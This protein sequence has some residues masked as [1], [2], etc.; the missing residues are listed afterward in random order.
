[1]F[2]KLNLIILA[3][4]ALLALAPGCKKKG[5]DGADAVSADAAAEESEGKKGKKKKAKKKSK[6]KSKKKKAQDK[7]A[8]KDKKK[9]GKKGDKEPAADDA[10]AHKK[11]PEDDGPP[12]TVAL[13]DGTT[14]KAGDTSSIK[15]HARDIAGAKMPERGGRTA[16]ETAAQRHAP[17]ERGTITPPPVKIA[18][19]RLLTVTDLNK[20]LAE[21]G[22][23]AYGPVQGIPPSE[24]YNSLIYRR[25][26]TNRFVSLLVWDFTE[27]SQALAR[28]NELLATYPNAEEL[29]EVFTKF[30]FFSYRNQVT[31]L[32]FLE[33]GKAMVLSLSCHSQV[34]DDSSLYALAESVFNRAK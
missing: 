18:V 24:T 20:H 1:M 7:K 34:C 17:G 23:V 19:A 16:R 33:P 12:P 8:K 2:S 29:K 4:F 31:S 27:Y 11:G 3:L 22:W 28:W 5:V 25:P 13:P 26:G 10:G 30:I 9:K 21:K 32:T 6:K 15:D 14:V